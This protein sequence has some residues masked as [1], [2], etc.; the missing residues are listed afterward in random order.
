MYKEHGRGT[1][2]TKNPGIRALWEYK[3]DYEYE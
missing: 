3:G 1:Y 2:T